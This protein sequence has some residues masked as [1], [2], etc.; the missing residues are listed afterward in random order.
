PVLSKKTRGE[1][2]VFQE[3]VDY[4]FDAVSHVITWFGPAKNDVTIRFS[5]SND[6]IPGQCGSHRPDP[7]GVCLVTSWQG[8]HVAGSLPGVGQDFGLRA[9]RLDA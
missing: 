8:L 3:G 1:E 5:W 9:V 2:I 4:A 6:G 7:N